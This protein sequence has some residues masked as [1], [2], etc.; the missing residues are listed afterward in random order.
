MKKLIF[1]FL[2]VCLIYKANALG[3]SS[4]FLENNT[5]ELIDGSSTIYGIRLQNPDEEEVNVRLVL[6]SNTAKIINYKEIYTLS[7]GKTEVLFNITAPEDARIGD[8]YGVGYYMEPVSALGGGGIPI[9]MKINK[10]FKV[11]IIRDTNKFY[12]ESWHL[13]VL[14]GIILLLIILYRNRNIYKKHRK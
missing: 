12:F 2:F 3:V 13:F 7:K 8:I 5:L 9:G 1:I 6:N 14:V 4:D 11:K 10:D